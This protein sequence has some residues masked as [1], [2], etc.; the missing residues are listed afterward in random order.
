MSDGR[1]YVRQEATGEGVGAFG[2]RVRMEVLDYLGQDKPVLYLTF[3]DEDGEDE[4]RDIVVSNE[5][6]RMMLRACLAALE[7]T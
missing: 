1:I 5:R 3:I 4:A 6:A 7:P 2:E